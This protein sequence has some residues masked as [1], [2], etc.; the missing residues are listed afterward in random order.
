M[1]KLQTRDMKRGETEELSG[2]SGRWSDPSFTSARNEPIDRTG[3]PVIMLIK[4]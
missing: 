1:S 2:Q 3:A 4:I